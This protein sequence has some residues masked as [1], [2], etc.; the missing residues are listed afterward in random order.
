[1]RYNQE[2]CIEL[3]N[4]F[5]ADEFEKFMATARRVLLE[6]E[7]GVEWKEF[8]G[9]SNLVGWRYRA[10]IEDWLR[11]KDSWERLGANVPHEELYQRERAIYGMFS[12]G[13][14]CVE[15]SVYAIAA[16]A[17]HP[18]VLSIPFTASDLNPELSTERE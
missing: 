6:R 11:Y 18:D 3:P 13:V 17:S 14:C 1:M 10:S 15:A 12:A 8:A 2:L 7:I 4:E 16:F 9:A 5:P